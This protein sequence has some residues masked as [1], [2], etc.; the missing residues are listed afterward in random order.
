MTLTI[1]FYKYKR[2]IYF[3]KPRASVQLL[4]AIIVLGM[5]LIEIALWKGVEFFSE[6]SFVNI[7]LKNKTTSMVT[8]MAGI[9]AVIGWLFTSR[10]QI[11]NAAKTHAMQALM[12]SRNSSIYMEKVDAA[13]V[14]RRDLITKAEKSDIKNKQIVL[15]PED[16]KVLNDSDKSAVHYLLNFLEFIATGVRHNNLDEDLIKGSFE[17]ILKNN[18]MLFYRVIDY[19]RES[20]PTNYIELETL[21]KRWDDEYIHS[22]CKQCNTFYKTAANPKSKALNVVEFLIFSGITCSLWLLVVII[23]KAQVKLKNDGLIKKFV[24][25]DCSKKAKNE[26]QIIK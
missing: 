20:N 4:F 8:V 12:N 13:T 19:V 14:I 24:C 1:Y 16:Y 6:Y 5:V 21:Y 3:F 9:A 11:I 15:T 23:K 7:T 22:K 2:D 26:N 18:Y 25:I 10:V 17:S